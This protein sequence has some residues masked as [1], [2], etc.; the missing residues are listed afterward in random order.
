[1][2]KFVSLF[3]MSPNN[4]NNLYSKLG[5]YNNHYVIPAE[6]L[7]NIHRLENNDI[8]ELPETDTS[9]YYQMNK[10]SRSAFGRAI[11]CSRDKS[12]F[13][14]SSKNGIKYGMVYK[15]DM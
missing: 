12:L 5:W 3:K 8:L 1:M 13:I 14:Q 9:F 15:L 4:Y 10:Y 7:I 6:R 11:I 2:N